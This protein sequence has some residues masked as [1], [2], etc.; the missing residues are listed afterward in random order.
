M[1]HMNHR[2][3]CLT[4]CIV[5]SGIVLYAQ[6]SGQ[7]MADPRS[8]WEYQAN[9]AAWALSGDTAALGFR[10]HFDLDGLSAS[11]IQGQPL[12]LVIGLPGALYRYTESDSAGAEHAFTS[13]FHI[14]KLFAFGWRL[15]TPDFAPGNERH[16]VGLMMRPNGLVSI[17]VGRN[18]LASSAGG[19][20]LGLGLR[21][22]AFAG[23]NMAELLT[24]SADA[25]YAQ[26]AF[27]LDALT[28][29]LSLDEGLQ[30]KAWYAP[31]SSSFGLGLRL[32]YGAAEASLETGDLSRPERLSA[33][34]A[35]R[36]DERVALKPSIAARKGALLVIDF[37]EPARAPYRMP[38]FG[39]ASA[40]R[41]DMLIEAVE[42]AAKD[43]LIGAMAIYSPAAPPSEAQAQELARAL[44]S[45]RATG[46]RI[47]AYARYQDRL[48]YLYLASGAEL[49][50]LDPN[51]SLALVD[52]GSFSLYY[53]AFFEKLGLRFYNLRSHDTKTA[54]NGF[55]EYGMTEAERAMK[56]RYLRGLAGQGYEALR[57]AR[58]DKLKTG[59]AELIAA[60]PYLVPT[61]AR[62]AGLVDRIMY[63]D[64]FEDYLS[65][66]QGWKHSLS[67]GEYQRTRDA[68]W[69]EHPL[70]KT[71]AV[72]HLSGSIISGPGVSG[73]SIGESAAQ[74]LRELR[75]DPRVRGIILRVDSGG[76][77]AGV[78]DFIAREVALSV[79][80]GKIVYVS[81]SGYAASG[82]Y[83]ISA[84]ANRIWAEAGTVTGSI[85]VTGLVPDATGLLDKLG[86]AAE[87]VSA[88][89]S[90]D[91]ANPFLPH[92]ES[93]AEAQAAA[94]RYIYERFID[95]VARGR[96]MDGAR[97]DELGKG[98]VW[99]GSEAL[100][101]GLIDELGGL[102]DVKA[103]MAR[104]LGASV[105]FRDEHPGLKPGMSMLSLLGSRSLA[106]SALPAKLEE[107]A[108]LAAELEALGAG[109]LCILPDY[110]WRSR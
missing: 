25:R 69:G 70:A 33:G 100:E 44:G 55:S 58:Q 41:H 24:L 73:A 74:R 22:L 1:Q 27:F 68:S 50:A 42:R 37:D 90:A 47:Y 98:Q 7:S 79:A 30:L 104:Q 35:L 63:R 91:F 87:S 86:I 81:M 88:G 72:L 62:D 57:A 109:P 93:D 65:D 29:R 51:G 13:S 21:P 67:I 46:K 80:E 77:D 36:V 2:R 97:V 14:G 89:P 45:F 23:K 26:D 107:L 19:W 4:L 18:D 59:A 3:Y 34:L 102:S 76:G 94:I 28:A 40:L 38:A 108:F 48:S 105:I 71:V 84:P 9:P 85:G 64:E 60:G 43:P 8:L 6:E 5:L 20:D 96:S 82:G 12:D 49:F 66:E 10:G 92:R 95:V 110:L 75:A 83:Y 78:S 61:A 52:I 106:A 54:F 15:R 17:G 32:A 99:L 31:Q 53:R 103:A 101:N 11:A 39:G 16:D 56:T